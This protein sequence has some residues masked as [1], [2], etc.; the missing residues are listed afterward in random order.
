[1]ALLALALQRPGTGS[2]GAAGEGAGSTRH[3]LGAVVGRRGDGCAGEEKAEEEG[4]RDEHG[5][6]DE[7]WVR[8]RVREAAR[9]K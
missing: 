6:E 3:E 4:G 2:D 9:E 5:L 8:G 1:L 7:R